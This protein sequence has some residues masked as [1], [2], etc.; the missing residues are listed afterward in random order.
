MWPNPQKIFSFKNVP[1]KCEYTKNQKT[2]N[3]RQ[4]CVHAYET[5][6]HFLFF[7]PLDYV[8]KSS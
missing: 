5:D 4:S 6:E 7:E 2:R 1:G 8:G 3:A